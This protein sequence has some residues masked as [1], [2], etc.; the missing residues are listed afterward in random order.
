VAKTT[1]EIVAAAKAAGVEITV[2]QR[3]KGTG[4]IVSLPGTPEPD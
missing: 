2:S 4:E 1:A 3:P